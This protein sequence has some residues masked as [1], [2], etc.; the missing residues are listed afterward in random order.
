M[1]RPTLQDAIDGAGSILEDV[2]RTN[3]PERAVLLAK[4]IKKAN[5]DLVGLQEVALWREQIPS[6][7]GWIESG[8][9]GDARPPT[10]ATT[11]CELLMDELKAKGLKYKVAVVQEEF[12]AELPA[13]TDGNDATGRQHRSVPRWTVG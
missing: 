13:D 9:I 5:P 3:F 6:D 2:D 10:S 1:R 12:D 4:E 11:G 8:G 7:L